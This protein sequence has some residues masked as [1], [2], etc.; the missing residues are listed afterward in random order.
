[1]TRREKARIVC[2]RVAERIHEVSPV[3]LGRW[4]PAFEV[5]AA[6]SDTF[7]DRLKEWETEDS[8]DTRLNLEV[9]GTTLIGAWAEA[10]RQWKEEGRPSLAEANDREAEGAVG[11]LVS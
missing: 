9:A 10:S 7:M 8:A 4:V 11:E 3:G 2:E 1:M 6:A 5:V